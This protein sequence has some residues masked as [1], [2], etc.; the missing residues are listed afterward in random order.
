MEMAR[1]SSTKIKKLIWNEFYKKYPHFL[2]TLVYYAKTRYN[3]DAEKAY[4]TDFQLFKQIIKKIYG[5]LGWQLFLEEVIAIAR[6][7]K[8]NIEEIEELVNA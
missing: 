6:Q 8:I 2:G 7:L 3:V 4:F 5:E 1:R